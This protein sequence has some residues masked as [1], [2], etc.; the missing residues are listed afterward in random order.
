MTEQTSIVVEG[1]S[2][3]GSITIDRW[4]IP[5]I[6]AETKPDLFFLQGF[7]AA[8]DRLWQIDL[9]RKRGLGLLSA[10]FGPG[11]LAQDRAARMFLYRGDMQA[12]WASYADDA[13]EICTAFINGINA[14]IGLTET[15]ERP[16]PP[17][18]ALLGT[19]PQRWQPEDVVR[20]RSHALTRNALS[21]IM[22]ANVMTLADAKTDLL[23]RS[24]NPFIEVASA[25]GV[26]LSRI[27]I[28]ALT[29]FKLAT[30]TVT[31]EPDRLKARLADERRWTNVTELGEVLRATQE[32]GS[33]NWV[34]SGA[35]TKSGRPILA[36]DPHR[37]HALPSLRYLVHLTM[38]G[39]DAIG[40]GEPSVP[41]IS[42]GHNGHLAF[43]L[44]IHGADQEDVYI[45]EI[46]PADP[47]RYRTLEG[48]RQFTEISER[49]AVKGEAE[50][51]RTITFAGKVVIL[52]QD[53]TKNLA[54]GM[55][56]A[57]FEPGTAAYMGS[58]RNMR[59][60]NV[61]DFAEALSSWGAPPVNHVCADLAGN[62]GW[63][64][65]GLM[66]ARDTWN[67]LLP[68]PGDG[69]FEWRGFLKGPDLVRQFNPAKGYFA[70]ANEMN[71]PDEWQRNN[72]PIG[73]EWGDDSRAARI[74]EVL[75]DAYG[76][77]LEDSCRLQCDVFSVPAQRICAH[78]ASLASGDKDA[79]SGLDLLRDWSHE[80][81]VDSAAAALFEVW[82]MLHLKPAMLGL[83]A[84][85]PALR[86]LLIPGDM[87]TLLDALD[88]PADWFGEEPIHGLLLETLS[89][90][91]RDCLKRLGPD[92]QAWGWGRL[93]H[94]FFQNPAATL[95]PADQQ[96]AWS[97]GPL[98]LGGSVSCVMNTG[99]RISDF[100][101]ITG[102]SVR[103]VMDVGAWDN[104]LCINAPGQSGD[105]ASPHFG[106]LAPIWAKSEFVP[107]LYSREAIKVA[108]ERVISVLPSQ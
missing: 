38:P 64:T 85:N 75:K 83:L 74:E 45:F 36:S 15:G 90:A 18:F 7:N 100:R 92:V 51:T 19:R 55:R 26:D 25:E 104:S 72:P 78:L 12:E 48:W 89:S 40:A 88:E 56:S 42:L 4:G 96:K 47:T 21:E 13:Q 70:T 79:Q 24:L 105:L 98:P 77:T 66:P 14:Y 58:L 2:A 34:L 94:G 44:T 20:I 63:M 27:P 6:Q 54:I 43:G 39:F 106:D 93:H 95:L 29:D 23:R 68:V 108:A 32:E 16:L 69:S 67:G 91:Y 84:G 62:I 28:A 8:R 46:D 87:G 30:A 59:A 86:P 107:L 37:S 41:G 5:H 52:W 3:P 61:A 9:W 82:W 17:E 60:Q 31:F 49:F 1:L 102:S 33:N 99:Y 76:Q 81:T 73:H 80:L 35:R 103:L 97:V 65:A 50:Q 101:C 22:R 53:P 71:L 10:D 11:Y 57:W